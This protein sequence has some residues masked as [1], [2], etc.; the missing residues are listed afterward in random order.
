MSGN[1][2]RDQ[3]SGINKFQVMPTKQDLG[4]SSGTSGVLFKIFDGQFL[5]FYMGMPRRGTGGLPQCQSTTPSCGAL[6][7]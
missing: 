7:L 4:I 6:C 2:L 5:P 1:V 3:G